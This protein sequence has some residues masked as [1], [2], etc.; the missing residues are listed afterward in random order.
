MNACMWMRSLYERKSDMRIYSNM[1]MF[2]V[3]RCMSLRCMNLHNRRTNR[4]W[5][6]G[7]YIDLILIFMKI[8]F[9]IR[10][11]I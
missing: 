11:V 5:L 6:N 1:Q 7:D 10:S 8:E 3:V 4:K 9:Y 2:I